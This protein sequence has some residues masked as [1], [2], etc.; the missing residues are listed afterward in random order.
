MQLQVVGHRAGWPDVRSPTSGYIVTAEDTNI[1][2]DCGAGTTA[3]LRDL[4]DMQALDGVWISHMHPDHC[5]DLYMLA[6]VRSYQRH[7]QDPSGNQNYSPCPLYLPAG[8]TA[9]VKSV[10]RLYPADTPAYKYFN[11]M[12]TE[13]FE[14]IEY[15]PRDSFEIGSCRLSTLPMVHSGGCSGI[16]LTSLGGRSIAYT[17]DTG[18]CDELVELA[19]GAE[20]L[21]SEAT[22][23]APDS[24]GH[25]HLCAREAGKAAAEGRVKHLLLTHFFDLPQ[26]QLE[27]RAVAAASEYDGEISVAQA[28]LSVAI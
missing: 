10:N 8:G 19:N 26:A 17:G 22:L 4:I 11:S 21:V 18:W 23:E 16:R 20:L 2:L 9:I 5:F 7:T 24:S 14:C 15:R 6:M 1:L 25:G 12:F 28:G 13:E 3:I 27:E